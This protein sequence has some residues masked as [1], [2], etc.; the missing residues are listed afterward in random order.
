MELSTTPTSSCKKTAIVMSRLPRFIDPGAIWLSG[1][2]ACLRRLSTERQTLLTATGTAGAEMIQRGAERLEIATEFVNDSNAG[3]DCSS[4]ATSNG[5]QNDERLA[6]QAEEL[7]VLGLRPRGNWHRL[8]DERLRSGRGGVV[9]VDLEGLRPH[10][11]QQ[12]L[13]DLGAKRWAPAADLQ[14]PLFAPTRDASIEALNS[15]N[16]LS[17]STIPI[18]TLDPVPT[19]SEWSFLTHTTRACPGPWPEQTCDD[20]FDSLLEYREDARHSAF[21]TLLRIVQQRRLIASNR[22]IRGSHPVVSFTAVPLPDLP[23]LRCFRG[24]RMRWDFEPYGVCVRRAALASVGARPVIYGTEQTWKQ[25]SASDQPFFQLHE[26]SDNLPGPGDAR[27]KPLIDW[28]REQE[29]RC[30]GD[31][32]LAQF[33]RNEVMIF[34]PTANEARQVSAETDWPVT[35]WPEEVGR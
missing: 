34:V 3:S 9:L 7:L 11:L 33:E 15:L 10:T 16:Y 23:E 5:S 27:N 22:T 12:E 32:D 26:P 28:M 31:L 4:V 8:L 1:L 30:L 19:Q 13:V 18:C 24:H 35:L 6:R 20:Y 2:N 29:W 17:S 14:K 21:R 25:M